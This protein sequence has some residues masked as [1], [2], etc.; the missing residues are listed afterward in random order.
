MSQVAPTLTYEVTLGEVTRPAR[1]VRTS[2]T[3]DGT[4]HYHVELLAEDGSVMRT[5]ELDTVSPEPGVLNMQYSGQSV[6]AGIVEFEDGLEVDIRGVGHEVAVVDPRRKALRTGG[7]AAGGLVKTQMPGRVVR[8][9]VSEGD[10]V[11]KDTPLVVVEAMKM[12]NEIKSP[13]EGT[14]SRV[15]VA[16]GDLVEA[17]AVLVELA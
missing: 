10:V 7:S 15:A 5:I 8:V 11:E 9:L 4:S 12:E 16:P 13:K 14:V 17:R 3:D 2:R 6:E 1:I